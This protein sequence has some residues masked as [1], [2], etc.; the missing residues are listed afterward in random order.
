MKTVITHFYNEEY[1]LPWW[2]EHHK[3]YFDFGILIDYNSTDNSVAICKEICPNWAVVP[4]GNPDF[5]SVNCDLEVLHYESQIQGW[6]IALTT[7]EFLVGDVSKLMNDNEERQQVLIRQLR[8]VEW[9]PH[10]TLDRNKPLWDQLK[11]GISYKPGVKLNDV[12]CRSLHNFNDVFYGP[13]R[14][15]GGP[16]VDNYTT[17][18]FV[19]HYGNAIV[20]YP[21][22]R[23]R[24][25]VQDRISARDREANIGYQHYMDSKGMD[26]RKLYEYHI[27]NLTPH[28]TDHSN[29]I[30]QMRKLMQ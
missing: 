15:W 26:L 18:A 9:D 3:K 1:L 11:M 10:G 19:F 14:H 8:F 16:T 4:S 23:R 27:L 7:T 5:D 24:L 6:R 29:D 12:Y 22:I 13:G 30:S 28:A 17:D 25:Q 20:G 2:L 21:M